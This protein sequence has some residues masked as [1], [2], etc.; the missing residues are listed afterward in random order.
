MKTNFKRI[1][2]LLIALMIFAGTVPFSVSAQGYE[3]ATAQV[4]ANADAA[5]EAPAAVETRSDDTVEA[6]AAAEKPSFDP[7]A[8]VGKAEIT[9]AENGYITVEDPAKEIN[10]RR[11][12][13]VNAAKAGT[14]NED[15]LPEYYN[16]R[17]LGYVNRVY[18]QLYGD[19]WA[20]ASLG[21][22]ASY[23]IKHGLDLYMGDAYAGRADPSMELSGFHL[24]SSTYGAVYDKLGIAT[25]EKLL[26]PNG[27]DIYQFGGS[28]FYVAQVLMG[29]NGPVN[30]KMPGLEYNKHFDTSTGPF[31][32]EYLSAQA[33][34]VIETEKIGKNN[35]D[36]IKRA[37]LEYGGAAMGFTP[38]PYGS[39]AYIN[40][41]TGAFCYIGE[42]T[43]SN[44]AVEL[45]GWDDNYSR[46]NFNEISRP[47]NN[48][49]WIVK[50]SW[51][52]N[53]NDG[54]GGYY[55]ISYE[56]TCV[57]NEVTFYRL[58]END[59]DLR[60]YQY[61]PTACYYYLHVDN[62]SSYASVFTALG[63]ESLTAVSASVLL[64]DRTY[65][66]DVY[67]GCDLDDPTTGVHAASKTVYWENKGY[68]RVEL[69]E[70][71]H[72]DEGDR[73]SIVITMADDTGDDFYLEIAYDGPIGDVYLDHGVYDGSFYIRDGNDPDSE[74]DDCSESFNGRIKGYTV[75]DGPV[76]PDSPDGR[77]D[78]G[79]EE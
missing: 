8:I 74:W 32:P 26:N 64:D 73:Y 78:Y 48:G 55:Y 72:L 44:H 29:G 66:V 1:F 52:T 27:E 42:L 2:A 24:I 22:C 43:G 50:N 5:I 63:D 38:Y 28:A 4:E 6:G 18:E 49:A 3:Q 60:I 57:G 23:M 17:D 40:Y 15:P 77:H 79:K 34:Q 31:G 13:E 20:L 33:A 36:A 51:G 12:A 70:P 59:P 61:D 37:L 41:Y 39:T 47:Q 14:E 19:C 65:T 54:D 56:T 10:E 21:A 9:V 45:V 30:A 62:G 58:A 16:S 35:P 7:Y 76:C 71:V 67:V 75:A 68:R 53:E 69:D 11:A 46:E 25:E